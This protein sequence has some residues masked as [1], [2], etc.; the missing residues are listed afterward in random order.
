MDC[1]SGQ[2]L[3]IEDSNN[4]GQGCEKLKKWRASVCNT[5]PKLAPFLQF[6]LLRPAAVESIVIT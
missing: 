4:L 2:P 3:F 6:S 5:F 1:F